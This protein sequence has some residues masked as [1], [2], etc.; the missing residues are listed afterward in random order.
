MKKYLGPIIVVVAVIVIIGLFM[1]GP[2]NR[3]VGL[4]E[5]ADK[6][7]SNIDNQLQRRV[8]LIPNLVDTVKGYTK[9][10]EK[11]FKDVS[12]ARSKLAG[13]NTPEEK[14]EA[15][16]EVNSA[17]SRLLAISE[18]Y[19]DLK[20][21]KQFTGLRDELAGTEN[22]IAVARKDYN[23]SINEYNQ[24]TRRFPSSIVAGLFNFD[25]KE[26]FQAKGEAKDAPKVYFGGDES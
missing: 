17:L 6:S 13:A 23:E 14:A 16:G 24:A 19:P 2:Y 15:N 21:D 3:L 1:I 12:D 11:V 10:E 18:N 9:H 5:E 26:Y 8:D 4:E 25:K 22:R 7:L 20:A